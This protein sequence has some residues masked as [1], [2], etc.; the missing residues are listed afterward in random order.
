MN[1]EH[2]KDSGMERILKKLTIANRRNRNHKSVL[3]ENK[4]EPNMGSS[5]KVKDILILRANAHLR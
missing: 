5:E 3:S 2:F 1:V 4:G